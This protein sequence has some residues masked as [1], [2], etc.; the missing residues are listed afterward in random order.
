MVLFIFF[1]KKGIT[2]IH[3]SDE[4]VFLPKVF[5]FRMV[6]WFSPE[7]SELYCLYIKNVFKYKYVYIHMYIIRLLQQ[8]IW[9]IPYFTTSPHLLHYMFPKKMVHLGGTEGLSCCQECHV[10]TKTEVK[11]WIDVR[12]PVSM[13]YTSSPPNKTMHKHLHN[14]KIQ[15]KVYSNFE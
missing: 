7:A 4:H 8:I 6:Q 9:N 5:R 3:S 12:D 11:W 13:V 2:V 15:Q 14:T 10:E 1:L